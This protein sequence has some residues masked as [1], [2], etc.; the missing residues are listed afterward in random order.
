[1]WLKLQPFPRFL[2]ILVAFTKVLIIVLLSYRVLSVCFSN[3][4]AFIFY[5]LITCA[6]LF[7]HGG[8][9]REKEGTAKN[10]GTSN[11]V[12]GSFEEPPPCT[13]PPFAADAATVSM[14]H[15]SSVLGFT[16]GCPLHNGKGASPVAI[17]L[18]SAFENHTCFSMDV[19]PTSR[20]PCSLSL[21]RRLL[22]ISLI[23]FTWRQILLLT[24]L[25]WKL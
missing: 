17:G 18:W 1:M 24:G 12:W 4:C 8:L 11:Q 21:R 3:W 16:G 2:S 10:I 7:L 13:Q 25:T 5:F 22:R 14:W 23:V 19:V 15:F 6:R 20:Q 9:L